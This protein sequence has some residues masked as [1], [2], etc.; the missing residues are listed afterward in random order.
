MTPKSTLVCLVA[1]LLA[2]PLSGKNVYRV[3]RVTGDVVKCSVSS[4]EW[5]P[6]H[7]RDTLKMSDRIRIPDGGEIRIV[8]SESGIIH[9]CSESGTFDVKQIID[10]SKEAQQGLLEAAASEFASESRSKADGE[11]SIKAHGATSRGLG[12]QADSVEKAMAERIMKGDTGLR[13]NFVPR[14]EGFCFRIKNKTETCRVCVVCLTPGAAALCLPA[15]GI[16]VRRGVTT[17][18]IPEVDPSPDSEYKIFRV[19][20]NYD[21]S[22]LLLLLSERESH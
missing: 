10:K 17:L 14:G 12:D 4:S 8:A 11:G 16:E 9:V 3:F 15:E 7:K 18:E 5:S 6:V 19:D 2:L 21:E 20:G 1:L 22:L 13:L